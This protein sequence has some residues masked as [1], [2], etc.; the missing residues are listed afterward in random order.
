LLLVLGSAKAADGKFNKK[1][2]QKAAEEAM[3]IGNMF[4]ATDAYLKIL[5][6]APEEKSVLYP[7]AQSYFAVNDYENAATYFQRFY[8]VDSTDNILAL[9]YAAICTKMQGKYN[10]AIPMFRKFAKVYK[11]ADAQKMK[12]WA[13]VEIDGCNFAL[14][15]AKPDPFVKITHMGMEVNSNYGDMAPTLR[16]GTLYFA[17]VNS[18]TVIVSK[19]GFDGQE[20]AE[21]KVSKLYTSEVSGE[22]YAQKVRVKT[23]DKEGMH[24]CNPAFSDDGKKMFYTLCSGNMVAPGCEIY[25]SEMKDLEWQDGKK[26]NSDINLA[27]ATN[28]QPYYAKNNGV[29]TLY[30]VS[31]R[32]GGR[33]GLD[34]WAAVWNK[35]TNEF[36]TAR[37]LGGKVNT[38]RDEVSPFFDSKTNNL[39]FSS[40]GWISMGGRDIYKSQSDGSGRFNNTAENMGAPFNS[41]CDDYDYSFGKNTEEGYFVSN[42]PGIY[43]VR[44]K[45]CCDDIFAYHYDRRFYLAVKGRVIDESTNQPIT[46][47]NINLSL[48]AANTSEGDVVIANDSSKGETPYFFNLKP[49]K[50]YK[51]SATHD[52]YFASSQNF[53][54]GG[55]TKSDT[56]VV[57]IYL[58][59]LEKN[60][61]Y[62]LNNIY[63]DFDK[64]DLR[65]ES[66]ITLDTLYNILIENP[67]IIIELSSHT[68]VRGSDEY[69]QNLSQ[70]R[71]ESCVSYLIKDKGIPKERITARG[72]GESQT[73]QDCTKIPEC[74]QD[75][76]GDCPCHQLNRR[77]EFKI[78]G[79]LDGNLI[80]DKE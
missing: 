73:L 75:Q 54:T 35:K 78:I 68:D 59:K 22:T 24:V 40:N 15:E 47:A 69:N 46:G 18:D 76:S 25:V 63:Y 60:K 57:D 9:Y 20:T 1:K 11:E 12:K 38:D 50:L 51:V 4:A 31:N 7:L 10:E 16:D 42:R 66:K 80:Y 71:A 64:W 58:K 19:P 55:I 48:R 5:E 8:E 56:Q 21:A 26:L 27:G 70:K 67:T 2:L 53:S 33:G 23:F 44:G 36:N 3:K 39:Y 32:E 65:P 17:S 37:N 41:A 34:I 14:K 6:K 52:G 49:E 62:R 61:A 29:E 28:T 43:S 45:T 30:F 77:T 79:E 74:P 72:Y 13:R